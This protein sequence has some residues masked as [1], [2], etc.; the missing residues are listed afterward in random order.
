MSQ[1]CLFYALVGVVQRQS[2]CRECLL[3]V[4]AVSK[5][6]DTTLVCAA[7]GPSASCGGEPSYYIERADVK[8]TV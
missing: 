1:L 3:S 7:V 2:I 6:C 8:L 5:T 4:E